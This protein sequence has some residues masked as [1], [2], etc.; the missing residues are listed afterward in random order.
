[1]TAQGWSGS[2]QVLRSRRFRLYRLKLSWHRVGVPKHRNRQA[3]E[4]DKALPLPKAASSR[5][6]PLASANQL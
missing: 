4:M 2:E 5:T 6:L 3:P 1:M